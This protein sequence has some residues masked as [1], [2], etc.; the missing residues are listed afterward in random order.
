M[1]GGE[2]GTLRE[3]LKYKSVEHVTM[4]EIDPI[5]VQ[6]SQDYLKQLHNCT[7]LQASHTAPNDSP[8]GKQNFYSCFD[9]PRVQ[10][11]C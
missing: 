6:V 9:D 2:G 1:G 5:V 3:V 8:N 10:L 7:F 11:R 4:I